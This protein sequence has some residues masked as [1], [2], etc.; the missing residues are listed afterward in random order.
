ME[1][2]SYAI[3]PDDRIGKIGTHI[4]N[5]RVVLSF[6][7]REARTAFSRNYPIEQV[8]FSQSESSS[9]ESGEV[10]RP[11]DYVVVNIPETPEPLEIMEVTARMLGVAPDSLE[12]GDILFQVEAVFPNRVLLKTLE[13]KYNRRYT[14]RS[15]ALFQYSQI[16]TRISDANILFQAA[17]EVRE[18]S[19]RMFDWRMAN[20]D[21]YEQCLVNNVCDFSV[22]S[23]EWISQQGNGFSMFGRVPYQREMQEL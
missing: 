14:P 5:N 18:L 19:I 10:L 13:D 7:D 16:K 15:T 8:T 23:R 22:Q 17:E 6:H 4:R 3:S 11:G 21:R 20:L 2:D 12:A 1:I 9:L